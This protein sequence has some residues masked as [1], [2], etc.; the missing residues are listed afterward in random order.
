MRLERL[1]QTLRNINQFGD[2]GKGINRLAYTKDERRAVQYL[3]GLCLQEGMTV[4]TDS[5]GNL[6]ARREGLNPSAP[7][8]A[9]GS[10][11]D[12]VMLGG[13]YDGALGVAAALE[14]IC[15]LNERGV[16][17]E[18][19]LELIVFACEESARFG[20]STI[21]SKAMTGL[22]KQEQLAGLKDA[23]GQSFAE[24]I[25]ECGLELGGIAQS[26]RRSEEF[27]VFFELHIEQGPVLEARQKQIGIA[28]GIAAPSRFQID[29]Q[30][31]AA[32]SGT[33][34]MNT[35]RDAFLSAAEIALELE[36]AALAE[37]AH[38]TVATTG[39]CDILPGAMNVVP[40][41]AGMK[42]DIRG[43]S[44]A[45]KERVIEQ[46]LST[47]KRVEES[48][49]CRIEVTTLSDE[50]PI[51]LSAGVAASLADSCGALGC[52]YLL[53]PSGAGHDAMNMAGICPTGLIFVPSRDGISHHHEEFTSLEQIGAGAAVLEREIMKW[54]V[55]CTHKHH[56][57]ACREARG[58][59][60]NQ[61]FKDTVQQPSQ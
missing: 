56:S 43:T 16:V 61:K 34:P 57:E 18:H 30:G 45:S 32:H 54:A 24:A 40:D 58:I 2:T 21:G 5:C 25:A 7:V 42:L 3:A 17:T 37:E 46:L 23:D 38:G 59:H 27:K 12:T 47:V 19:P 52:S 22:L 15:S 26:A 29:I 33:T 28:V 10:H 8:V 31:H 50:A 39:V 4:R 53:M 1:E 6:I 13:E 11:L 41:F 60:D 55:D 35:R 51:L 36:R 48:R 44:V 14:V 20:V 9:F 49:H